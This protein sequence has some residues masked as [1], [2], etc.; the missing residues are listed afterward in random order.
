[1][2]TFSIDPRK[3]KGG[4][5]IMECFRRWIV[6]EGIK[7]RPYQTTT[8]EF[9]V[10]TVIRIWIPNSMI[11]LEN[12]CFRFGRKVE[13]IVFE[14]SSG[15][16]Q[17]GM[18]VLWR[19]CLKSLSLPRTLLSILR[20]A[21]AW[22]RQL[23]ELKFEENSSLREIGES[24]FALTPIWSIVFPSSIEII[25]EG[26][27]Y[28]CENLEYISFENQSRL[29]R[30]EAK[31]FSRIPLTKVTLPSTI[32]FLHGSVF[33]ETHLDSISFQEEGIN[34]FTFDALMLMAHN[35][36]VCCF[37]RLRLIVIARNIEILG[38]FSFSGLDSLEEV[39]FD[40]ESSLNEIGESAFAKSRLE[41]I[42]FPKSLKTIRKEA[43]WGCK[44]FQN[45][46][47]EPNSLIQFIGTRAFAETKVTELLIPAHPNSNQVFSG[48][49]CKVIVIGTEEDQAIQSRSESR[50]SRT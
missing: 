14:Y 6:L 32:V 46:T 44:W 2:R 37:Q 25:G 11:I 45:A 26:S 20:S 49:G 43:F 50:R 42:V 1:V 12:S 29:Q 7:V 15:L 18:C 21:F 3:L 47:F 24:A 23:C 28:Q 13:E 31:A 9:A 8:L 5:F 17:I 30:I 27:F 36:I 19:S 33:A 35:E 10:A 4:R 48:I 41:S 34:R 22:C 38:A 40:S 39:R 16:S